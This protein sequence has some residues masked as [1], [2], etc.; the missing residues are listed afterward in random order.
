MLLVVYG[1]VDERNKISTSTQ[2]E[3]VHTLVNKEILQLVNVIN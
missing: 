2:H 3:E 1:E